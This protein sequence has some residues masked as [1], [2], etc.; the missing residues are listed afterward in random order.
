MS[1]KLQWRRTL[2]AYAFMAPALI[3]FLLFV[4]LPIAGSLPLSLFDYS[5]IGETKFIGFANFA[6]AFQDKNFWLSIENSLLFVLVVPPIQLFSIILAV[7]VNHKLAGIGFFRFLYYIPVVTS[8]VAVSII[9]GFL[10]NPDGIVNST[11]LGMGVIKHSVGFL[12]DQRIALTSLMFITIWQGLGYYMMLYLSGLQSFPVDIEEAA[13][14]DGANAWTV[15]FRIKIPLLKPYVWFC[16][17]NSVISAVNVFDVVFVLTQGGPNGS[18]L[19]TNYYS[20]YQAFN[21]FE[22]G[23][24]AAVGLLLSVVTTAVSMIVFAYGK[25]GGGMTYND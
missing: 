22:F 7:L 25:Q 19:V 14:V 11:L 3:L 1:P 23:Y 2:T 17:L 12:T 16:T 24:S 9:W 20:Y 8:M 13:R 15:L 10:F 21:N 4:F 5:V 6:R 18:T